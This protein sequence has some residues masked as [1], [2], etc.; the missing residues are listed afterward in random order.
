ML[1]STNPR[2]RLADAGPRSGARFDLSRLMTEAR[3]DAGLSVVLA[4]QMSIMFVIA[5]LAATGRASPAVFEVS[6][7]ILAAA[8][9]VLLSDRRLGAVLVGATVL[10]TATFLHAAITPLRLTSGDSALAVTLFRHAATG[11]FDIAVGVAVARVAFAGGGVNVHRIMGAVVL[12]L[13]IGLC[14]ANLFGVGALLLHPSFSGLT[15]NR[16]S[17]PSDL[18]YFSLTT[19]TT[20]GYGDI[21]PVHPLMRSL[22]NLESVIGQLYPATLLAR[23]VS[24]HAQGAPEK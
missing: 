22:A 19:L 18:L 1:I 8:A 4:I 14:F 15:A 11:A 21:A 10:S 24:L 20:T 17:T 2:R 7:F 6:R 13:A 3:R 23:L 12:Y 16:H 9:M 5:P